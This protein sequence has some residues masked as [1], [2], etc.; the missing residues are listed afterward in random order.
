MRRRPLTALLLLPL[1]LPP[2]AAAPPEGLEVEPLRERIAAIV[3]SSPVPPGSLGLHV[4]RVDGAGEAEVFAHRA[5]AAMT[6]ASNLKLLTT[7]AVVDRLDLDRTLVTV[8]RADGEIRD[9]QLLGDLVVVGGGDPGISGRFEPDGDPRAILRRWARAVAARG[10][11][12]VT[13]SLV[14]DDT[15]FDRQ[16]RSPTWP[17]AGSRFWYQAPVSALVYED[18][19][20]GVRVTPGRAG[21]KARL[22]L[23]PPTKAYR[24]SGSV[25]TVGGRKA[26][27][28]A[29]RADRERGSRVIRL[30]GTVAAG[31]KPDI[32][33]LTVDD[34]TL[35][36]GEV[37]REV[38][39]EEGIAVA[40]P[41][42][43]SP[44]P[45]DGGVE[46]AR[47]ETT[48]RDAVAVCNKRSQNLFAE[49][50]VKFLGA[51]RRGEGTWEAG[52]AEVA[53]AVAPLGLPPG[54]YRMEDGSGISRGS[55]LA[56]NQLTR[57][58]VSMRRHPK[59]D[60]FLASMCASG[61]EGCG[62]GRRL[63]G[64]GRAR[65]NVWA[66]TGSIA[67]VRALSGY[68][69]TASGTFYAWSLLVNAPL[70]SEGEIRRLQDDVVTALLDGG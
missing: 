61:E 21:R 14:L 27:R 29:M 51:E 13:G 64:D 57:L 16:L 40:G 5:D 60:D 66:K 30:S 37:F 23:V 67:G 33:W 69:R 46:V 34:P 12:S 35:W 32:A 1:L 47:H 15:L 70:P 43:V 24:I 39:R 50:L 56:P 22:E 19:C 44:R 49:I 18:G 63:A 11:R 28:A 10:I 31:T 2:A 42:V 38:L 8:V 68:T 54:S 41:I 17:P 9:R 58:L 4:V 53:D 25:K 7:A 20:V 3:A 62:F 65:E 36:L 45:R 6:P 59:A 55:L 48:L 26:R 52:L